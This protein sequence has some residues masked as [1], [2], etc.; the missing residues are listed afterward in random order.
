MPSLWQ[1]EAAAQE[2]A[3]TIHQTQH[4]TISTDTIQAMGAQKAARHGRPK[5]GEIVTAKGRAHTFNLSD[6][7]RSSLS[8]VAKTLGVSESALIEALAIS[9]NDQIQSI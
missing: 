2:Q 3:M 4:I 1:P 6:A 7:A 5:K 9:L 8:Q